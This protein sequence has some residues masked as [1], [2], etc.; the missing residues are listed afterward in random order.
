[1]I[2][3]LIIIKLYQ[4]FLK[5]HSGNQWLT[6]C[7]CWMPS[8]LPYVL[9]HLEG[10]LGNCTYT[11]LQFD[12]DTLASQR[13][14]NENVINST[15]YTYQFTLHC[16]IAFSK[17]FITAIDQTCWTPA[18]LCQI[19]DRYKPLLLHP[20]SSPVLVCWIQCYLQRCGG[21]WSL[22]A[23]M[24]PFHSTRD[25][26]TNSNMPLIVFHW[27]CEITAELKP[28]TLQLVWTAH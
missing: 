24:C 16:K 20:T 1:M 17:Y 21:Q 26:H 10:I 15:F 25:C 9:N 19:Q 11:I 27:Q 13:K 22:T 28:Q 6:C 2:V 3:S 14:R 8:C 4:G 23:V 12:W 5:G 7:S 18:A